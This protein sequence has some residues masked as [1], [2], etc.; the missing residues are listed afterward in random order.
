MTIGDEEHLAAL[1]ERPGDDALRVRA[2]AHGAAG[3]ARQRL[4]P[5]RGVHVGDDHDVVAVVRD[6]VVEHRLDHEVLGHHLHRAAG[7]RVRDPNLL[8]VA[9]EDRDRLGHEVHGRLDE[10]LLVGVSHGLKGELVGVRDVPA[11]ALDQLHDLAA[12]VV[13]R[14]QHG[15]RPEHVE[16]RADVGVHPGKH[17]RRRAVGQGEVFLGV[18]SELFL[19]PV[20]RQV[21]LAD[22]H[23]GDELDPRGAFC[24]HGGGD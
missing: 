10:D 4:H 7:L 14:E 16:R 21:L 18:G 23:V 6:Q 20:Q 9:G 11:V 13:V 3:A 24:R 15:L 5:A 19:V 8:V 22:R 1:R 2:G 12:H 17:R